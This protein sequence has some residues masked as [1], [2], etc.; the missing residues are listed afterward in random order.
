VAESNFYE[1]VLIGLN[2]G[3]NVLIWHY[4]WPDRKCLALFMFVA[5]IIMVLTLAK[6]WQIDLTYV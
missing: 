6:R 1:L 2:I 5:T 4:L 3:G